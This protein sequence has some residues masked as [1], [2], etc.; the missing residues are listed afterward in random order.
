MDVGSTMERVS[1]MEKVKGI[2]KSDHA[3]RLRQEGERLFAVMMVSGMEKELDVTEYFIKDNPH[4]E[5]WE[6]RMA[7][8]AEALKEKRRTTEGESEK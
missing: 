2:T 5:W 1:G 3:F 8:K 7:K 4:D 6:F